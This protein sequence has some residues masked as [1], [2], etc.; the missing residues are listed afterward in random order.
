M[1]PM[2]IK[3]QVPLDPQFRPTPHTPHPRATVDP[4]LACESVF[5]LGNNMNAVSLLT[6]SPCIRIK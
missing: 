6:G 3:A 4:I 5:R 2:D 1:S